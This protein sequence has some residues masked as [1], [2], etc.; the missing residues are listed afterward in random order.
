MSS[1]QSVSL[2]RS[3]TLLQLL[4]RQSC[5]NPILH[6]QLLNLNRATLYY[7]VMSWRVK[8][9][10]FLTLC[11]YCICAL[12][13][14]AFLLERLVTYT[15][16]KDNLCIT[17]FLETS[18]VSKVI[19]SI[20][21]NAYM[22]PRSIAAHVPMSDVRAYGTSVR[23]RTCTSSLGIKYLICWKPSIKNDR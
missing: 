22:L 21:L 16:L 3:L 13:W 23:L 8:V 14:L 17:R 2:V 20:I 19:Y 10:G 5:W 9:L 6:M 7:M 18:T 1:V 12:L 15:C 11:S 4:Q